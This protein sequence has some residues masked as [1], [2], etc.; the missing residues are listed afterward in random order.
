MSIDDKKYLD[1]LGFDWIGKNT[2]IVLVGDIIDQG[3]F[4]RN[5]HSGHIRVSAYNGCVHGINHITEFIQA[6]IKIIKFLNALHDKA[7]ING[8]RIFKL[9]G[10]HDLANFTNKIYDKTYYNKPQTW[11]YPTDKQDNFYVDTHGNY[12]WKNPIDYIPPIYHNNMN[13][14]EYFS[15]Y[16]SS[17]YLDIQNPKLELDY[18]NGFDEF[19]YGDCYIC[20]VI[21]N[22]IFIH[23]SINIAGINNI[24]IYSN[25]NGLNIFNNLLNKNLINKATYLLQAINDLELNN[26]NKS[27][28]W[29]RIV[30]QYLE[31]GNTNQNTGITYNRGYVGY[32]QFQENLNSFMGTKGETYR[33]FLGHNIQTTKLENPNYTLFTFEKNRNN[34]NPNIIIYNNTHIINQRPDRDYHGS[35]LL[36]YIEPKTNNP[37]LIMLDAG[38]SRGED[39]FVSN[40]NNN[41]FNTVNNLKSE[42]KVKLAILN[43]S[44]QV[45][46][47]EGN[48]MSIIKSSYSN[49]RNSVPRA[50]LSGDVN[51]P[52]LIYGCLME[53][54]SPTNQI[55]PEY[56]EKYL[57]YKKKYLELKMKKL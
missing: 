30:G 31:S 38:M 13:R 49:T 7:T 46:K 1:D 6:E 29:D 26:G 4:Q 25:I 42:E 56:Y 21:N 35:I 17:L 14:L 12:I 20:I 16:K 54:R 44:P 39:Y 37:T 52:S 55:A 8:G 32:K 28:L 15:I 27:V 47:I 40:M 22:N 2:H 3:K 9:I 11:I 53:N 18:M 36:E 51:T 10:N 57:K 24:N 5:P 48:N 34:M 50:I 43:T 23:G 19:I 33:L 41:I 45:F